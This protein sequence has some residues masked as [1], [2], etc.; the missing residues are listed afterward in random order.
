M[1]NQERA[2]EWVMSTGYPRLTL[3]GDGFTLSTV[4]EM[5]ADYGIERAN[6]ELERRRAAE[7]ERDK[8]LAEIGILREELKQA[9]QVLE[10]A[11]SAAQC[12][13]NIMRLIREGR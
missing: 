4:V 2:R 9:R 8:A 6:A 12:I 13:E 7:A 3:A 1:T 10:V 11:N 5:L